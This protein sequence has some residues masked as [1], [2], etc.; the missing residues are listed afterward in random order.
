VGSCS[1][2]Q[3]ETLAAVI[4]LLESGRVMVGNH[5]RYKRVKVATA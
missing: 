4:D 3:R 2:N 1:K 5:G